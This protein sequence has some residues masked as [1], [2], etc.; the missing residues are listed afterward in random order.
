M[1]RGTGCSRVHGQTDESVLLRD[2][3][4]SLERTL[5]VVAALILTCRQFHLFAR[6]FAIRN[7]A[8][9]M[10]NAIESRLPFI[11]RPDDVPRGMLCICRFQHAITSARVFIPA[12]KGLQIHRTEFPLPYWV[13]DSSLETP[14]LLFLSD[15]QPILDQDNP[16]IHDIVFGN[17]TQLQKSLVLLVR[18]ETHDVFNAGTVVPTAVENDDLPGSRKVLHVA[19]DIHLAFFSVGRSRK[20]DESE[21][22]RADAFCDCPDGAAL[23]RGIA[24]FKDNNDPKPFIF[25][26]ILEFTELCLQTTQLCFVFLKRRS[27]ALR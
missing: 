3:V 12:S 23:A 27:A 14:L 11:V 7:Q 20:C 9:E 13:I 21:N 16:S 26:P 19:L 18:T 8:Q 25:D 22:P 24:P 5:I 1:F 15:F 17:R 10:L 2:K 4:P 6:S